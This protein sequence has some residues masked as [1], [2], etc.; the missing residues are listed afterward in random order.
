MLLKCVQLLL[1]C[2]MILGTFSFAF[3]YYEY[4]KTGTSRVGETEPS[5]C[6]FTIPCDEVL[7]SE[8]GEVMLADRGDD[9]EG[10]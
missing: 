4:E 7:T 6:N 2:L 8:H 10:E 5:L 3:A 9:D 1:S